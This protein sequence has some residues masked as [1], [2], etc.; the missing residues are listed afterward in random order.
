MI[1]EI[2]ALRLLAPEFGNS[3]FTWTALIGVIR[4]ASSAGSY[5]GG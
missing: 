4:I 3:V 1:V 5:L 2:C